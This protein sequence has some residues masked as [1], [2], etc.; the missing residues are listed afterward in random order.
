M[1]FID[2][3][4]NYKSLSIVGMDKNTG[5]TECL[6]YIINQLKRRNINI[7]ITSIGIDGESIDQV[8]NTQ[9]PEI[10]IFKD[11]FFVTSELHYKQRNLLS[12]IIDVSKERTSLGRL[13]TAKALENGKILLSGPSNTSLLENYINK[14]KQYDAAICIVDGALSRLS[15][16]SPLISESLIL[17]T[18]AAVSANINTLVSK[19]AFTYNLINLP[20]YKSSHNKQLTD[21]KTGLYAID[22]SNEIHDLEIPS[23]FLLNQYKE[24]VFTHGNLIYASGAISDQMLNFLS[25]QKN[26]SDIE[27]IVKDFTRF[28]VTKEVYNNYIKRGGK[29]SVLHKANLIAICINPTSPQGA[30]MDSLLLKDLLMSELN[31]PIYDIRQECGD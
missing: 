7:F 29:I 24:R 3:I 15:S 11:S 22:P 4:L 20:E 31:I 13:V 26:C 14:S 27:L 28:F 1:P 23:V 18:G 8:T 16:A 10:E 21:L 25:S 30:T 6:N 17:T 19:T 12:E 9:K 2:K 5:K